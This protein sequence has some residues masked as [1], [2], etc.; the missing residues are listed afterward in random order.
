MSVEKKARHEAADGKNGMTL[1]ELAEFVDEA[2]R[3]AIP[4]SRTVKVVLT[5]RNSI[6][7]IQVA[8]S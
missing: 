2:R 7:K 4:G 5:W 3:E 8:D 6:K 1:D